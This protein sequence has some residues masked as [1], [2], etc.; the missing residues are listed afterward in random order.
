MKQLLVALK[1]N[2][3][4]GFSLV[5]LMV[6]LVI[7][8][9]VSLAVFSA[10]NTFEGRKRTVSSVNDIDQAGNYA[11]YALDK[12]L[13]SAG[14]GFT[15]G[16][17]ASFGCTLTAARNGVQVLPRTAALPAP[18]ASLST[19]TANVFKLIPLLI[20]PG[21]TTPSLS[22]ASSD[23][24]VVMAGN[25]G[26]GEVATGFSA[27]PTASQ[28]TINSTKGF[29]GGD[30]IL[31]SD[32]SAAPTGVPCLIE[33]VATGFTGGATPGLSLAANTGNTH[34]YYQ[35]TVNSVTIT[36][37]A[38]VTND[39]VFN[40]G[41]VKNG[42][43]PTFVVLGVGDNNTLFGFDLLQNQNPLSGGTTPTQQPFQVADGVFEMHARYGIDSNGDDKVDSWVAATGSFAPASLT[44]GTESALSAL[45]QIRAVR[46]A[47]IM[48]TSLAE[49]DTVSNYGA[50]E[51]SQAAG[52]ITYFC[53]LT[54]VT[55]TLSSNEQYYRYRVIETTV[56]LRNMLLL[57]TNSG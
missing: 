7:G 50:S 48:R 23:G 32:L 29:R 1:R 22:G 21:A 42:S 9:V 20:V 18:F 15:Q 14:S 27:K 30:Q 36:S 47:L 51:C 44:A 5:E 54:S 19:G 31:L 28:L 40:L 43:P 35:G 37:F 11:V 13:R 56:P 57:S 55:R 33:E 8:L 46:V 39:V 49:K 53:D 2:G 25:S 52:A 3:Q 6:A 4:Q 16:A 34:Y 38:D 41:N 10:L 26:S 24:L 12:W 17:G 45:K